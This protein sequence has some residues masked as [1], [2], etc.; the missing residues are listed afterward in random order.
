MTIKIPL[1]IKHMDKYY[2]I[3]EDR[4]YPSWLVFWFVLSI[5][6]DDKYLYSKWHE[7][8]MYRMH[9]GTT[10]ATMGDSLRVI[11]LS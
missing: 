5:K 11:W 1:F 9:L 3:C 10:W 6:R 4:F 2:D 7:M 8:R